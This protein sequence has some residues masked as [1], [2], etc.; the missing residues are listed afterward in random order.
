MQQLRLRLSHTKTPTPP[1]VSRHWETRREGLR[2]V[3]PSPPHNGFLDG[4]ICLLRDHSTRIPPARGTHPREHRSHQGAFRHGKYNHSYKQCIQNQNLRGSCPFRSDC[5]TAVSAGQTDS[6]SVRQG[7]ILSP[8][9][10]LMLLLPTPSL[11]STTYR[12]TPLSAWISC[13]NAKFP[14][15]LNIMKYVFSLHPPS[16]PPPQAL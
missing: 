14:S 8:L 5:P 3:P 9:K 13:T 12:L 7:L 11:S 10:F 4:P 16:H 6:R 1:G 2:S 15:I